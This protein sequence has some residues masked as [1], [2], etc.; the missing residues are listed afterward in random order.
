MLCM[1][2]CCWTTRTT[3]MGIYADLVEKHFSRIALISQYTHFS[4]LGSRKERNS[5]LSVAR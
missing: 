4:I 5:S 1:R 3:P 2:E